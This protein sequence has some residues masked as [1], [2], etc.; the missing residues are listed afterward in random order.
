LSR[1]EAPQ[2]LQGTPANASLS[3]SLRRPSS[4]NV[5]PA[6]CAFMLPPQSRG[7]VSAGLASNGSAGARRWRCYHMISVPCHFAAAPHPMPNQRPYCYVLIATRFHTG[8][9]QGY[10]PGRSSLW[11]TA[12]PLLHQRMPQVV[13]CTLPETLHCTGNST[14][15][16][17]GAYGEM[18]R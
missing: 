12:V 16:G 2:Q 11:P 15:A 3:C 18:H 5:S 4:G 9:H 7:G 8:P 1:V 6:L 14:G 13:L 17:A 10:L